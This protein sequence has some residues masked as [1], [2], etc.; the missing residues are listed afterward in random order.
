MRPSPTGER[1]IPATLPALSTSA[2]P[3]DAG[4]ETAPV[5]RRPLVVGPV[6]SETRLSVDASTPLL[7]HGDVAPGR[8]AP[9]TQTVSP[10]SGARRADGAA[11][12]PES[13]RSNTRSL[14]SSRPM[15]RAECTTPFDVVT[16]AVAEEPTRR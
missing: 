13:R 8:V 14:V 10:A 6:P 4:L 12:I 1:T 9:T 7:I 15:T 11:G 5:S 16:L 2:P 3:D